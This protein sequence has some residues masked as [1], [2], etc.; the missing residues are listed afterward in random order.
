M[1][2]P[3]TVDDADAGSGD[4]RD[5]KIKYKRYSKVRMSDSSNFLLVVAVVFVLILAIAGWFFWGVMLKNTLTP[6]TNSTE[7]VRPTVRATSGDES[8][9]RQ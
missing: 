5:V 3:H 7:P 8:T 6:E 4:Q 9:M 1:P 2:E